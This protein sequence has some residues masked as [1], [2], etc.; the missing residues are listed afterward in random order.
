M[1]VRM[2][3]LFFTVVFFTQLLTAQDFTAYAWK[4][5]AETNLL[6]QGPVILSP[7]CEINS[8]VC[9]EPPI[10][11]GYYFI[12][13]G[14]W[15]NGVWYG[16]MYDTMQGDCP[17]VIVDE[18]TGAVDTIGFSEPMI[19]GFAYD[20]STEVAYVLSFYGELGTINLATG[21]IT[22]LGNVGISD[23]NALACSLDGQLYATANDGNLYEINANDVTSNVVGP[24]GFNFNS[25]N[26]LCFDRNNNTLYGLI[27]TSWGETAEQ[28]LY[29][30]DINTGDATLLCAI[31][32]PFG[33]LAIPYHLPNSIENNLKD[34]IKINMVSSDGIINIQVEEILNLV[35]YDMTGHAILSKTISNSSVID[36]SNESKGMY[37]LNFRNNEGVSFSKRIMIQ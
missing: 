16:I 14:D 21:A 24:L 12:S 33:G 18:I 6:C 30:I 2:F 3:T 8:L 35:V 9:Y 34:D 1:K 4:A 19:T 37:L 32:Y 17:L 13:A 15:I 20:Y 11:E 25:E 29:E 10:Y 27:N 7:G 31:P 26:A 36:L 5:G 23:V 22:E 28:G